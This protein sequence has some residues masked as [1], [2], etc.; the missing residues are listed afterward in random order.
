MEKI[1]KKMINGRRYSDNEES[2]ILNSVKDNPTNLSKAFRL[3]S[4]KLNNRNAASIAK[5]WYNKLKFKYPYIITTGSTKGF[6]NNCK[7]DITSSHQLK[8]FQVMVKQMLE[9]SNS[10]RE[11]VL[12]FFK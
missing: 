3:A 9:L 2:I 6:S 1:N 7:N 4:L 12:N 5:I 11:Q 10:D 8:P